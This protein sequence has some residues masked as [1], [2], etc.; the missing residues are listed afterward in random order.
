[1]VVH[2]SSGVAYPIAIR[3]YGGAPDDVVLD[4]VPT[5][6]PFVSI[7]SP[8]NNARFIMG[9]VAT[10]V[11]EAADGDG[12]IERIDF[13]D[14]GVLIGSD[15]NAPYSINVPLTSG[16]FISEVFARATDNFGVAARSEP[17]RFRVDY[18]PPPN[19]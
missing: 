11:A 12:G 8:T 13:F 18:P 5:T 19:D 15:T 14:S 9:D 10:L 1:V 17:V 2:A 7:T 6:P 3:M 4:I 16:Y